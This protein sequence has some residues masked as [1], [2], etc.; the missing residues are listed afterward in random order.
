MDVADCSKKKQYLIFL[1]KKTYTKA[2]ASLF[3][4]YFYSENMTIFLS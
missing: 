2:L 1:K 4:F 3:I